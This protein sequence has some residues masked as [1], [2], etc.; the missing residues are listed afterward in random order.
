MSIYTKPQYHYDADLDAAGGTP[1]TDPIN[2]PATDPKEPKT[3]LEESKDFKEM[4]KI[5]KEQSAKLKSYEDAEKL[6][7]EEEMIAKGEFDK[8]LETKEAE[9]V[10]MKEAAKSQSIGN[11]ATQELIKNGI[12]AEVLAFVVPNLLSQI[13][14]NDDGEIANMAELITSLP[15]SFFGTPPPNLPGST[16]GQN[17]GGN[18]GSGMSVEQA[19]KLLKSPNAQDAIDNQEAIEKALNFK[20]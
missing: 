8:L 9:I 13:K 3:N 18:G 17:A 4:K 15:K 19:I 12:N 5:L 11:Q 10:K 20:L 2:S 6:K 16:G 1:P 7:A 14:T